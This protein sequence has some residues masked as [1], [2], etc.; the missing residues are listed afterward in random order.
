MKRKMQIESGTCRAS[1]NEY[2]CSKCQDTEVIFYEEVNE[3]GMRVSMQK[4]CDCKAQRVLER[5]LKNAMIPE[6]FADARFDSYMRET[7]EQK[8]LYNTMAKYLKNFKEIRETKQNSLGFIATFGELRIK[9]LEPA[10][11][12]E[13]KRDHNSFGLGKTHLQASYDKVSYEARI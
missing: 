5:R 11:R 9:Q 12:A 1:L 2:K 6:E 3:F 7:E 8:L 10:K 13:A 4:D